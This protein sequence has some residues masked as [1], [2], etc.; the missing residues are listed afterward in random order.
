MANVMNRYAENALGRFYVDDECIDCDQCR[1][2]APGIFQRGDVSGHSFV[3]RQPET[4]EEEALCQEA[5]ANCPVE[6][7]GDNGL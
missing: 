3:V 5:M 1:E 6:A 2:I 4:P 7:I